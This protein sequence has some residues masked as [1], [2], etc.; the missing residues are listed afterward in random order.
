LVVASGQL[1]VSQVFL[2]NTCLVVKVGTR[3]IWIFHPSPSPNRVRQSCGECELYVL[4]SFEVFHPTY[5]M[6]F[7]S[8]GR[9]NCVSQPAIPKSHAVTDGSRQPPVDTIW[10]FEYGRGRVRVAEICQPDR[11]RLV[12]MG[13]V[14]R[15]QRRQ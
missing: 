8:M 10:T 1:N 7:C 11:S 5:C 4:P 6:T 2:S 14:P 3:R 13:A 12:R 9:I 15:S